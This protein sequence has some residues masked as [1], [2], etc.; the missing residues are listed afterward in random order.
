MS[1]VR[2]RFAAAS[3]L[4]LLPALAACGF[5]AQTDA[6]YQPATGTN[7]RTGQVWVLNSA[8][9]SAA[10]GTG[11]WSG[12]L[13]NESET[14]SSTLVSVTG[15]SGPVDVVAPPSTPVNLAASGKI[16]LT[17]P[18]LKPGNFTVLT[19]TFANGQTT[20]LNSPVVS[21]TGEFAEVPTGPVSKTPKN[22]TASATA[23]PTN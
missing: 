10:D 2:R 11:T 16:R 4:V 13:I 6:V 18:E 21:N 23:T 8:I 1:I 7:A 9:V 3:L 22:A 17:G 15:A 20:T 19:F 14:Q 12:T 5:N